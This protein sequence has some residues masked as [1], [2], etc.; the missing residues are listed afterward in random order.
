M[1]VSWQKEDL[2]FFILNKIRKHL[3]VSREF[4]VIKGFLLNLYCQLLRI[5]CCLFKCSATCGR[6]LQSRVVQCMHK[7]TGRHGDNCPLTLRP[8]IYRPC[9][10]PCS[11]TRNIRTS[12]HQGEMFEK[13]TVWVITDYTQITQA[14]YLIAQASV[15]CY[16]QITQALYQITHK[17][18]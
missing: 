14:Q 8:P 2:M 17:L 3:E 5:D 10:R 6:G 18:H 11:E 7:E 9:Q 1:V 13:N 4:T 12:A 15:I 16:K